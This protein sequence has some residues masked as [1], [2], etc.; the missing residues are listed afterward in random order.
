[1]ANNEGKLFQ[2]SHSV[3]SGTLSLLAVPRH[4]AISILPLRGEWDKYS[5]QKIMADKDFNPPTPWGVGRLSLRPL[6]TRLLFQSSH[7]VGSG[8]TEFRNLQQSRQISILPLRG[9]WDHAG[10]QNV[11]F[12]GIS[13]LPLRGEWDLLR[14]PTCQRTVHFN[15]PTPWG[16]GPPLSMGRTPSWYFNPPTP[17]GVGLLVEQ[18]VEP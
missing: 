15:P 3:G 13:I 16:V 1:M 6:R 18:G 7:S 2:S 10:R 17:W 4:D 11:G 9:E 5:A 12:P 14:P 8:T